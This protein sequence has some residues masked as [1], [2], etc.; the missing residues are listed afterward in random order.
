MEQ[1]NYDYMV[2]QRKAQAES[3]A[4]EY[5][6][7][8]KEHKPYY[9]AEGITLDEY[10]N[11]QEAYFHFTDEEVSRIKQLIIDTVNADDPDANPVSTVK[12][13]I[14]QLTY[15]EIFELSEELRH[16]LQE[17]CDEAN[18]DPENIDFDTRHYFY[19]FCVVAYDYGKDK[20]CDPFPVEILLSDEDY[21][22]LLTLQLLERKD[23]C[24]NDLL[25]KN[26]ELAT[27][28]NKRVGGEFYC[29]GHPYTI[30]FDEVRADAEAIDGPAPVTENIFTDDNDDHLFHVVA[31]VERRLLTLTEEK[32][33]ND[34]LF[35]KERTL[36]GIDV[37]KVMTA[38]EVNSY[39]EMISKFKET[40]S[41]LS[42]FDDIK[43]WL[44]GHD[45]PF[46]EKL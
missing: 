29:W 28:L 37:N 31:H 24:F 46:S 41:T 45:I 5:F 23:F 17:R 1:F 7:N 19:R 22:S 13:A 18:L 15:S 38:L 43:V 26:P 6:Y 21:I 33:N 16:L 12:E 40:F 20:G 10:D 30:L 39:P 2:A 4:R 36:D 32:M 9:W 14:D 8:K 44:T 27:K 3:K 11:P 34:D 35:S 42:A 25:N